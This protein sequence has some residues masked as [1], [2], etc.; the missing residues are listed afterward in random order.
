MAPDVADGTGAVLRVLALRGGKP[1]AT[2]L[3]RELDLRFQAAIIGRLV[4]SFAILSTCNLVGKAEVRGGDVAD[5]RSRVGVIE[6]VPDGEPDAEVEAVRSG[7]AADQPAQ[8]AAAHRRQ[9]RALPRG[10]GGTRIAGSAALLAE[11]DR[12]GDPQVHIELSWTAPVVAGEQPL[13]RRRI[14]R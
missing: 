9:R 8:A 5:N 13:T 11:A 6:Q 2:A 12:L 3:K 7:R 14:D 1:A 4:E 10:S